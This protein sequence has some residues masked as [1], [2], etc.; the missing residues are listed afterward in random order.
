MVIHRVTERLGMVTV[1]G[2][3]LVQY[4]VTVTIVLCGTVLLAVALQKIIGLM[5]TKICYK[6]TGN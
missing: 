6:T 5:E 3:G 2:A 4:I 1:A